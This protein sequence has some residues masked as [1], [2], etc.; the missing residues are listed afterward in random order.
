MKQLEADSER[1]REAISEKER[2]KRQAMREWDVR[3]R[4]SES[5]GMRSEIAA[6]H[7]EKLTGE[8]GGSG[9]AF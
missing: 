6:R 8:D 1:L 4:E 7:L 5:A 2:S 3:L 9:A